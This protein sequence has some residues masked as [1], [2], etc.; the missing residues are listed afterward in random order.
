MSTEGTVHKLVWAVTF[1]P[2]PKN[3]YVDTDGYI[4]S[5]W[6]TEELAYKEL[7]RLDQY[8]GCSQY[9]VEEWEVRSE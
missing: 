3:R 6:A 2:R 5:L 7:E 1:Y 4:E 9:E 8:G